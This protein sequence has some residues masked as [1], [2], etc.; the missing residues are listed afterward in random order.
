MIPQK[1]Y[2]YTV[3]LLRLAPFV[4]PK[5]QNIRYARHYKTYCPCYAE[6]R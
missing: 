6:P 1:K 3:I 2:C 5:K 4:S